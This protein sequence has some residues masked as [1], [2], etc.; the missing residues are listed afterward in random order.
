MVSTPYMWRGPFFR[1]RD[2]LSASD[3]LHVRKVQEHVYEKVI[4]GEN[5]EHGG[6][7]SQP[8]QRASGQESEKELAA[9]A[10]ARVE[11][12]CQD[13]VRHNCGQT[14]GFT[15]LVTSGIIGGHKCKHQLYCLGIVASC[16]DAFMSTT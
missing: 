9:Q 15:S 5:G 7:Q 11:L 1:R 3:M 4:G 12:M 13:Q 10:E 16:K 6:Q 2:R 14:V 8:Q